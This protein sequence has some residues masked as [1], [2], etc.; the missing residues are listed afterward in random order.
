MKK[1]LLF[2]A[3][4]AICSLF[5]SAQEIWLEAGLKGGYGVSFLYNTNIVNDDTYDYKITTA[6]SAG[7][8]LAV[9]FGPFHGLT[10]EALYSQAGQDFEYSLSGSPL[11]QQNEI[12]WKAIN[13]Y[14]LYR[15]IRNRVYLETGPMY[16][17]MRSVAQKDNGVELEE[18]AAFYEKNYL[19]GVFGFGGYI[20]GSETFSV[21]LGLR[22]HY[23]LTDF[24][25]EAGQAAGFPNPVR[26]TVYE[27]TAP[28]HPVY[29][30]VLVEFNFGI[31]HWAKTS[32]SKRMQFFRG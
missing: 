8:K 13:S 14:L 22:L 1:L 17:F 9:N 3:F 30:Q 15:Y 28:T 19:A 11:Q 29:G 32:C 24:V 5:L 27:S 6:Y 26:E 12:S 23:G 21:G 20:A 25:N 16:A 2:I 7:G 18:P 10:L 4:V 31:G